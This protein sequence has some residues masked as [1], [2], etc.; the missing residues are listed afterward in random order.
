MRIAEVYSLVL[1]VFMPFPRASLK[2]TIEPTCLYVFLYLFLYMFL[3]A[4]DR[5]C[6]PLA[7]IST[8][9]SFA[10][11]YH[12]SQR[13]MG[14]HL[15]L[16]LFSSSS[17]LQSHVHESS[18]VVG[19]ELQRLTTDPVRVPVLSKHTT[20][21]PAPGF[22]DSAKMRLIPLLLSLAWTMSPHSSMTAGTAGGAA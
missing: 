5:L 14:I 8:C 4:Q 1:N 9:F 3:E 16:L 20:S 11:C 2:V 7:N 15:L 12:Y 21:I 19:V 22:K 10:C 17:A 6:V 13:C 18:G